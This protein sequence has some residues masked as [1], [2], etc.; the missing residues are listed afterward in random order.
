MWKLGSRQGR[1]SGRG[2]DSVKC[3][4]TYT[5]EIEKDLL[6]PWGI[7]TVSGPR[8]EVF[9]CLS[10]EMPPDYMGRNY[11]R[12][13]GYTVPEPDTGDDMERGTIP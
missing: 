8:M 6:V 10:R 7:V 11:I 13:Q 12:I 3:L 1:G 2:D 9:M 4:L 5:L